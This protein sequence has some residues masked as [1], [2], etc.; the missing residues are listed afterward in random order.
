ME[1]KSSPTTSEHFVFKD[2]NDETEKYLEWARNQVQV[3][4]HNEFTAWMQ[5]ERG[6]IVLGAT[7]WF[8]NRYHND[9][10]IEFV[11]AIDSDSFIVS[12]TDYRDLIPYAI[13]HEV[14]E[15]Y[16]KIL[17]RN[18]LLSPSNLHRIAMEKEFRLAAKDDKQHRLYEF[19]S[20]IAPGR[21]DEYE[22]AYSLVR[23]YRI[24]L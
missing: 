22:G 10:S 14:Q 9:G 7:A 8:I 17:V 12:E 24:S 13:E 3:L 21:K 16:A 11:S 15:S 20:K 1:S 4:P 19:M 2:Y 6:S 23:K 5:R 18:G